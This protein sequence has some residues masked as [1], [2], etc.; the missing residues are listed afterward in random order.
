M[1]TDE[2]EARLQQVERAIEETKANYNVLIG[3]RNELS[4]WIQQERD[5][6]KAAG[7]EIAV[8]PD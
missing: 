5:K 1:K 8:V 6:A 7:S 2:L 4:F 3:N